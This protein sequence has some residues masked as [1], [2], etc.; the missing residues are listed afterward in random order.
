MKSSRDG[1]KPSRF[2]APQERAGLRVEDSAQ[3]FT[4]ILKSTPAVRIQHSRKDKRMIPTILACFFA[5]A[6]M[7][8]LYIQHKQARELER[9]RSKLWSKGLEA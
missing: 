1:A 7:H 4:D 5:G 6:W 9:L 8:S 2:C 3:R